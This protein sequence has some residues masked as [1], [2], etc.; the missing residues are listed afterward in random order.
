M[1]WLIVPALILLGV[2]VLYMS[3]AGN[4]RGSRTIVASVLGFA[5]VAALVG[6]VVWIGSW[7]SRETA[8]WGIELGAP[9]EDVKFL[10]GPPLS[11]STDD[12]WFYPGE[13]S[14]G[15]ISHVVSYENDRVRYIGYVARTGT[16]PVLAS[17]YSFEK[18]PS[19]LEK[20]GEPDHVAQSEDGLSRIYSFNK[21]NVAFEFAK[22]SIAMSFVFDP[23]FGPVEY[24]PEIEN[25]P[26]IA[27]E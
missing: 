9:K 24:S 20:L 8:L 12:I 10:K 11:G 27:I 14:Q 6:G 13:Y 23:Q 17:V 7:P 18:L 25:L 26:P 3:A 22:N 4:W 2:V 15:K 1:N 21:F 16:A 19:V 5:T